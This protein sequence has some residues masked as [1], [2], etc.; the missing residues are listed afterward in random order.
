[1]R[2]SPLELVLRSGDESLWAAVMAT[3]VV[4]VGSWLE[5]SSSGVPSLLVATASQAIRDTGL[6]AQ[7]AEN[8]ARAPETAA[9]AAGVRQGTVP[10]ALVGTRLLEKPRTFSGA[11]ADWK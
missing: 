6:R 7:A 8:R 11:L 1:M 10:N 5:P 2:R 9:G 3:G 4:I